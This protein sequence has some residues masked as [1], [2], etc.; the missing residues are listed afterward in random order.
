MN[1]FTDGPTL[2][3]TPAQLL[4]PDTVRRSMCVPVSAQGGGFCHMAQTPAHP[5]RSRPALLSAL[6]PQLSRPPWLLSHFLSRQHL[7]CLQ[8][9]ASLTF[10]QTPQ[11]ARLAP[12]VLVTASVSPW[13]PFRHPVPGV[14]APPSGTLTHFPGA[15]AVLSLMDSLSC[16]LSICPLSRTLLGECPGHSC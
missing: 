5:S 9:S 3:E 13:R 10:L 7:F 15:R 12:L 11:R 6:R 4:V 8:A 2:A 14:L 16:F 1:G